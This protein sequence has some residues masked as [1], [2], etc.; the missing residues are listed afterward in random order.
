MAEW[1]KAT[2]CKAVKPLVRIQL[3]APFNVNIWSLNRMKGDWQN[4]EWDLD[5]SLPSDAITTSEMKVG[6]KYESIIRGVVHRQFVITRV[7]T[8]DNG[9]D[10]LL[11]IIRGP[12]FDEKR[13]IFRRGTP[14]VFSC[15][16]ETREQAEG[17]YRRF[18]CY[19][20]LIE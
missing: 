2:A 19:D 10:G 9:L 4:G 6:D 7:P 3:G 1:S 16:Y 18:G 13:D 12:Y 11:E 5:A 14:G 17:E 15:L 20:R 8:P